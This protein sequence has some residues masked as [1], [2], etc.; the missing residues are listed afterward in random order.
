MI[1]TPRE[2]RICEEHR[3]VLS[4]LPLFFEKQQWEKQ[5]INLKI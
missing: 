1:V 4:G 5:K 3:K 2:G